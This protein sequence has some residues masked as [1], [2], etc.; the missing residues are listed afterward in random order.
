MR[1]QMRAYTRRLMAEASEKGTPVMRT[2]FYEFPEDP[3]CWEV[4]DIYMYGDKL[5]VAPILESG[6][7]RRNIYLPAGYSWQDCETKVIY[8]GGQRVEIPVSMET[9]PVFLKWE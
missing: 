2:L 1:E 7:E 9:M 4:E 6:A 8:E 3:Y 5:L